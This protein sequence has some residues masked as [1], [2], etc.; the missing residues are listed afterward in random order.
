MLIMARSPEGAAQAR[1]A[2]ACVAPSGLMGVVAGSTWGLR[3]R[4]FAA[5]ALRLMSARTRASIAIFRTTLAFMSLVLCFGTIAFGQENASVKRLQ[6]EYAKQI[7]PILKQFCLDCHST[8][9]QEGEL[10]LERFT[11]FADV[12]RDPKAWQ[13]VAEML[14]NGE[15]PPED[16]KQPNDGQRKQLRSWVES[17]LNAEALANAGDPGPVILR[18]LNNAEYNYTVRDLTGIDSLN[19]TR[20]FPIDGAA[21]EGFTNAGSAQA[22]SPSLV[23]KYLDAA[24]TVANHVVLLPDGIR[25]SPHVTTRDRT[26]E[27]MARIQAFY[28]EFTED[29][30]G[31]AVNLQ[32]IKFDTN[33]GGVL[34]LEKYLAATLQERD[35][36]ASGK[37]TVDAVADERSLNMKYLSS[38]WQ[39]LSADSRFSLREKNGRNVR[40]ANSDSPLMD[41]LRRKW[42]VAKPEDAPKLAADIAES[43]KVLWKYNSIG[44][45]GREGQPKIWMEP[46]TPLASSHAVNLKLPQGTTD[47]VSVFLIAS[48]AGDGREHDYVV[49]ENP[50]LTMENGSDI[51][52][53]DLAGLQKRIRQLQREA[54]TKT[55]EYLA[56]VTEF[57]E[58]PTE[59]EE[60][61]RALATKHG[62]DV[63]ALNVWLDYLAISEAGPVIVS[64]H[65]KKTETHG[66]YNFIRSWGTSATPIVTANSSDQQVRIP[67][68][69]RPHS[70]QAHPSPTLFVA[71]GW[72]S[73]ITGLVQVEARLSDAHPECGNGQ[74]WFVQHRASRK[75]GNL[76]QGEFPTGGS[77]KMP[78]AK[79]SVRRGELV[80]FVLGPRNGGHAC[81]LTEINLVITELNGEKRTWDLAKDVSV[82]I[83]AGN[84]HPDSHGNEK[85]WHFYKGEMKSVNQESGALVSVPAG[86]LLARWQ[87]EREDAKRAELARQVQELAT[88]EA[89]ADR[90]SPDGILYEQ[91]M[92]L[93]MAPHNLD[94]LLADVEA[95]ERFGKHPL[96]H[97]MKPSDLIVQAPSVVEFRIPAKLAEGRTLVATGRLDTKEGREGS[98][99]LE[100]ATN[101]IEPDALAL[102]S[103]VVVT[104]GS[105]ARQRVESSFAAFRNLFPPA[106]CYAWIVPV[107]EVV[108][109]TLFYRQDDALQRLMLDE[110]QIA[111]L[112]RLWD[113]LFYV[114]QEPLKYQVAFEQIREFATQDRPDLVKVWDPL[115]KSVDDRAEAFRKRLIET[116]PAHVRA[117]LE[118]ADRAWRRELTDA[119]KQSVPGLYQSLREAELPHEDAI[120]LTMARVLASPAFLYRRE[121]PSPVRTPAAVT[122]TELANRLSY[123]LWSSMPD[124]ELARAAREGR[125][126][127]SR[128]RALG[129]ET[130]GKAHASGLRLNEELLSQT[131]RMLKDPRTRRLAIQFACQWLHL[132]D[133]DHDVE[134]NEKLYPDFAAL[135]ADMYEET[136]RFFEDMFRND[137]S[138]LGLLNADH[139]FLNE[140]LAK[141]YGIDG[142]SG[143][144]WRRVDG[145]R[146]NGRSGLLGMATVLAS[147]SGASRTSPILR[148]NWIYET[149][150]GERLPRPP[151]NVPEIPDEPPQGLTARQLIEKHSSVPAC[152]KCH[153]KIDSY[154]FA[155]EQYDT[156]GRLRPQAVDTKTKLFDGKTVDGIDGL[157]DYLMTE[158]RADVV[159]Q[160]C[161][162][163]LGYSLGREVQLSDRPLIDRMMKDLGENDYRFSVAVEAIVVSDQFRKVRGRDD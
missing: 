158:R 44:H 62:L 107:D 95:D 61:L 76:W 160:F 94:A 20:E 82:D 134:K 24:K 159:R 130:N 141:H 136:V 145:V 85:T 100:V 154:G 84:P 28:R 13:K 57:V 99:K 143:S 2:A 80:S 142:V 88:A 40:G 17:Y 75:I 4:L 122:G 19:P 67:G 51:A 133:F 90:N 8:K 97:A 115:V 73:P 34:P 69:S 35:A 31:Q 58:K 108:T 116:E 37:T 96:G 110:E 156:V 16:S 30:G 74:E 117:L 103:P 26:D 39:A 155:L 152:A 139:T 21:G 149:L 146:S 72:Q 126:T 45:I 124:A 102:S 43:Q 150:L 138:I 54:L 3:P 119:E 11:A 162:K 12:R 78:P 29:G 140:A 15:M 65:F 101:K 53:R 50:R 56:A 18:R 68:I 25:F 32:G 36:L 23:Q 137:G 105:E 161:R 109:L 157:R 5:A 93:A 33:Q 144:E 27:L 86:S 114:A 148:G 60:Q 70:I 55:T 47:D 89:P 147:Q 153:A 7:H 113:E 79:I 77:A 125:L 135:R 120:R 10:D 66:T 52:L 87:D 92:N 38:V 63:N 98:V 42:I 83:L 81:D 121:K 151:A 71:A 104:E 91:L 123:F 59:S 6:N 49:W 46:V 14:D 111:E 127:A 112:D 131:R 128:R 9:K 48:D 118:F 106:L 1:Q 163:L 64:G 22:M 132:R 41:E 129:G